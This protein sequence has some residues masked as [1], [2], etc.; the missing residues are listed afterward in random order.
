[1]PRSDQG[2][3]GN[4]YQIVPRVLI[5]L[6]KGEAVLLLKGAPHKRLWANLYNGIGGHIER[7]EDALS[8]ARRELF[9][10]AGLQED[11][12]LCGTIFIDVGEDTGIGIF[13]YRGEY[14]GHHQ[15]VPS[16]EGELH[17]IGADHLDQVRLV[18]DLAVLLPE[19][20]KSKCGQPPFSAR[21][22]YDEYD[23]LQIKIA[24]NQGSC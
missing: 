6:T 1:M 16:Q 22:Y 23:R 14:R 15:P 12:W 10:E 20:L 3:L 21:Y 19:V 13:V 8:A 5:F 4:R 11:L 18:E 9:E 17:W 7:G 2:V 24:S